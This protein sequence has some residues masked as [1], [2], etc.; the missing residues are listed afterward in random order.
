[1]E[2]EIGIKREG[3]IISWIRNSI[4]I[5]TLSLVIHNLKTNKMRILGKILNLLSIL[6]LI[7]KLDDLKELEKYNNKKDIGEL[8]LIKI[9][10]LM[11]NVLILINI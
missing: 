1:M 9:I 6:I 3:L 4:L 7:L 2:S 10:L 5:L 11:V 8:Y